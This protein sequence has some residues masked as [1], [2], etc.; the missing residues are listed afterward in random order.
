[1]NKKKPSPEIKILTELLNY[2]I[3]KRGLKT[4]ADIFYTISSQHEYPLYKRAISDV[5]LTNVRKQILIKKFTDDL[6]ALMQ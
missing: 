3:L 1:M 4:H 6:N 2:L 5:V